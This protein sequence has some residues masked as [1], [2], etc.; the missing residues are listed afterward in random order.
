MN[1]P[2]ALGSLSSDF[3]DEVRGPDVLHYDAAMARLN[4]P[5]SLALVLVFGPAL[6]CGE[7]E[8]RTPPRG[9]EGRNAAG[10][11]VVPEVAAAAVDPFAPQ[12]Q[13]PERRLMG[14]TEIRETQEVEGETT[15]GERDFSAELRVALGSPTSCGAL[16][17]HTTR[18]SIR[19]SAV[20][21]E[22]GIVTRG[23]VSGPAMPAATLACLQ[24][25]LQRVRLR[26]EI[27]NAPITISTTIE[28]DP[29]AAPPTMEAAPPPPPTPAA[30]AYGMGAQT[31]QGPGGRAIEA[32]GSQMIEATM[33]QTISGPS[34]TGIQ[35]PGGVG[36]R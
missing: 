20:V 26:G 8:D 10:A 27:E 17:A 3:E 18:V 22:N 15:P 29:V 16:G 13:A 11:T 1:R 32:A 4:A 5:W 7:D 28:L 34:G 33:G 35:G 6:G 2:S 23:T 30:A 21:T 12:H 9:V 25:R 14:P 19:Y 36:I 31:I 24:A